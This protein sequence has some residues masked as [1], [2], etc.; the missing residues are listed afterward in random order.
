MFIRGETQSAHSA[1]P[2][3]IP[4]WIVLIHEKFSVNNSKETIEIV[5]SRFLSVFFFK[6]YILISSKNENNSI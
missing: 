3:K 4:R 2:R 5:L 1:C 6:F